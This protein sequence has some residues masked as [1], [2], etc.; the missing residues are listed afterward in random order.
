MS[1]R[2]YQEKIKILDGVTA[3]GTSSVVIDCKDYRNQVVTIVGTG[4]AVATIKVKISDQDDVAFGSAQSATNEWSYASTRDYAGNG[5]IT[6]ASDGIVF[7]S[8]GV[9]KHEVNI[10]ATG[11]MTLQ[12]TS[13]TTGT[14]DAWITQTDNK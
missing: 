2:N 7:S 13:Y 12:V 10:N 4:S 14:F 8:A 6:T 1:Q 9:V 5:T 11:K 3:A